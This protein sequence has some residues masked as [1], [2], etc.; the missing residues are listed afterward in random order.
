VQVRGVANPATTAALTGLT[1]C[2]KFTH[3][4]HLHKCYLFAIELQEGFA[5]FLEKVTKRSKNATIEE[6]K[7]RE[8]GLF[9]RLRLSTPLST[10]RELGPLHPKFHFVVALRNRYRERRR[11]WLGVP[12]ID[13]AAFTFVLVVGRLRHAAGEMLNHENLVFSGG[14]AVVGGVSAEHEMPTGINFGPGRWP[15]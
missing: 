12:E 15:A 1:I 11:F 2:N 3:A 7:I 14:G 10:R 4:I 8:K 13:N 9:D 6:K 5:K